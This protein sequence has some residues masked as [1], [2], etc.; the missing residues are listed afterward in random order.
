MSSQDSDKKYITVNVFPDTMSTVFAWLGGMAF[1]VA[2][3]GVVVL[4]T[5]EKSK[6][7]SGETDFPTA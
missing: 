1:G 7:S 2:L 3:A 5:T 6:S 4:V